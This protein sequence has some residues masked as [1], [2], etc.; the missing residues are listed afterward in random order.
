MI[1]TIIIIGLALA[2]LLYETDYMRIRLL[3]GKV[4]P[5]NYARYKVYNSMGKQKK[6]YFGAI[7]SGDNYPPDYSPNGAPEYNII[8]SPGIDNVLCGYEWLDKHKKFT[9][10]QVLALD[11]EATLRETENIEDI[12]ESWYCR[13]CTKRGYPDPHP[14]RL[15]D[16]RNQKRYGTHRSL[17]QEFP[18]RKDKDKIFIGNTEIT[19]P[20]AIAIA[21][22][23]L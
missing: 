6:Y 14:M 11:R 9:F 21:S 1:T 12:D 5:P 19:D 16:Y 22:E 3:V 4:K 13:A 10:E 17:V 2:W 15:W 8:L 23:Y 18:L 7:H 20:D